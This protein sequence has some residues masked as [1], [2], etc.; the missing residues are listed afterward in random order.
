M[1]SWPERLPPRRSGWDC[2]LVREV[3]AARVDQ[4]VSSGPTQARADLA[5]GGRRA[6]GPG[7]AVA[8]TTGA[9]RSVAGGLAIGATP[10]A[11]HVTWTTIRAT[12]LSALP[13]S[14]SFLPGRTR[15][16]NARGPIGVADLP[17]RT[18]PVDTGT[19]A[20]KDSSTST[21]A[22]GPLVQDTTLAARG[23]HLA[24]ATRPS[25]AAACTPDPAS[26]A[27]STGCA[28]V[29][30][31]RVATRDTIASHGAIAMS[32]AGS[33]V[34]RV[35]FAACGAIASECSV[36]VPARLAHVRRGIRNT[37]APIRA[38]PGTKSEPTSEISRVTRLLGSWCRTPYRLA[39]A[40]DVA[41]PGLDTVGAVR[42]PGWAWPLGS[43]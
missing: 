6:S 30:R 19:I 39:R 17:A 26:I 41:I 15:P 18:I 33:K 31:V 21:S 34:D 35:R 22:F 24:R 23:A 25:V 1:A 42:V 32:A 43:R 9:R 10:H 8:G 38:I 40:P 2:Q 5:P 28:K 11:G 3:A 12:E 36:A 27:T 4:V 20:I 7:H 14:A 16:G 13:Q 29:G 37:R